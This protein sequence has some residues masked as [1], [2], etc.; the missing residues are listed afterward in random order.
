MPKRSTKTTAA[1]SKTKARKL[2]KT[3][4]T[5]NRTLRNTSSSKVSKPSNTT[6]FSSALQNATSSTNE[7]QLSARRPATVRTAQIESS[8]TTSFTQLLTTW[9]SFFLVTVLLFYIAT[10]LFPSYLVFG[11]DSISA[12]AGMLQSAA[13]LSVIVVGV[14]PVIEMVAASLGRK[15]SDSNWMVFYLLINTVG[16]WVLGRFAEV[17]G[18]GISSWVVA[19]VLGFVLNLAQGLTY[20]LFITQLTS[21]DA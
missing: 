14:I 2:K 15:V 17:I 6:V 12:F 19:L 5:R 1:K 13:L 20:K 8:A 10:L 21:R 7:G 4:D 16:I 11:T 9:F 18:M 3:Q